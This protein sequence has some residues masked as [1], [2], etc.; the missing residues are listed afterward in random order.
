MAWHDEAYLR[1][2]GETCQDNPFPEDVSAEKKAGG[3]L[4]LVCFLI[5][6]AA[7][8]SGSSPFFT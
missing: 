7:T 8:I 4:H 5:I 3:H 1:E 2:R 6:V